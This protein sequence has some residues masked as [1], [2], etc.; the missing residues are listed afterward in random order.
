MLGRVLI[1]QSFL[2]LGL[3]M[4]LIAAETLYSSHYFYARLQLL[5]LYTDVADPNQTYAIYGE[6]LLFDDKVGRIKR[7][8]LRSGIRE[9]VR[10]RL[11]RAAE[12]Y[13]SP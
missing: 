1:L 12:Q 4:T 6:R 11:T 9:D 2:L 7:K 3:S 10:S 8:M 5:G 13:R